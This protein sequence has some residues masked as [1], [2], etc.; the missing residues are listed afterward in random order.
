MKTL[1]VEEN[2]A[3]LEKLADAV[4]K[5]IESAD[6][7]DVL[8]FLTGVFVSLTVE[9]VRRDGHDVNKP[10]MVDGGKN[11]DITIHPPKF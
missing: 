4:G 7:N 1:T 2:A 6:I 5:A 10:I 3:A 9:I 8:G 11:R